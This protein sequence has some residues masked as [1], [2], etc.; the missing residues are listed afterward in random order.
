MSKY[1]IDS[2]TLTSIADAVRAKTGSTASIKVSDIPTEISKISGGGDLP[3]EAFVISGNCTKRFA[4][5]GWNWFIEQYGN[6]ITTQSIT[7]ANNMFFGSTKL[8]NIPFEL[9]FDNDYSSHPTGF[10]F[11][12]CN[13][14]ITLPRIN[15]LKVIDVSS[16]FSS[17]Y[18]LR[19]IPEDFADSFD[20]SYLESQTSM[21]VGNQ[22]NMFLTCYS[23]RS[24]PFNLINI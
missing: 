2:S 21:Y 10:L 15:N 7:N 12:D 11:R 8:V 14:L 19:T 1:V 24:F 23:L 22:N 13:K 5:N 18:K 6:K 20:W 17:C 16:M 4:Y 9:N 3:E